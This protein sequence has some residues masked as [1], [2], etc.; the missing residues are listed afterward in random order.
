MQACVRC[1]NEIPDAALACAYCQA[2]QRP[3]RLMSYYP[4]G[5]LPSG[6]VLL[7]MVVALPLWAYCTTH[8]TRS[9]QSGIPVECTAL[10]AVSQPAVSFGKEYESTSL[11]VT[12]TLTNHGPL[13]CRSVWLQIV[14]T[15]DQGQLHDV[16]AGAGPITLMPGE[17]E[18]FK[19]TAKQD[20]PSA[21]YT[22]PAVRVFAV[23]ASRGWE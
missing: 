7:A 3:R 21:S 17:P 1:H 23:P 9:S 19:I 18:S 20:F 13:P 8:D 6:A 14:F 16:V 15:D 5:W 12:G 4:A 22:R 10:V 11:F 2:W